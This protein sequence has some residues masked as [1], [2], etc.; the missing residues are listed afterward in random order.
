MNYVQQAASLGSSPRDRRLRITIQPGWNRPR[1]RGSDGSHTGCRLVVGCHAGF[2]ARADNPMTRTNKCP[3]WF[4]PPARAAYGRPLRNFSLVGKRRAPKGEC[5]LTLHDLFAF[6]EGLLAVADAAAAAQ[7]VTMDDIV[8]PSRQQPL[9]RS[10]NA[11][12]NPRMF[13]NLYLAL[14]R[15]LVLLRPG[16]PP[17]VLTAVGCARKA[18][19]AGCRWLQ[20]MQCA[21]YHHA[22]RRALQDVLDMYSPEG[23]T[24]DE[25]GLRLQGQQPSVT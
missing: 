18:H 6:H 5:Y 9:F 13:A 23:C 21:E 15:R 7:R 10:S 12:L 16:R 4:T 17:H 19:A 8:R 22:D 14:A 11:S 20:P 1:P 2:W 3:C 25:A 24:L